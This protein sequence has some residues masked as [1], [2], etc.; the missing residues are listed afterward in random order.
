[1]SFESTHSSHP[2]LSTLPHFDTIFLC[3][4][5]SF[6]ATHSL[7]DPNPCFCFLLRKASFQATHIFTYHV[8]SSDPYSKR[9]T[10]FLLCSHVI[11]S[12]PYFKR[13]TPSFCFLLT[14]LGYGYIVFQRPI[15]VFVFLHPKCNL[16]TL[17]HFVEIEVTQI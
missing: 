15:G 2:P 4:L 12:D 7:S 3:V 6:Q 11:S 10:P 9:S 14:N 5:M 13:F 16:F 1:M 8:I 17:P